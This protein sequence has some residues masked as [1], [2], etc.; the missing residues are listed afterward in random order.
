MRY[1]QEIYLDIVRVREAFK[2]INKYYK[3]ENKKLKE[4]EDAKEQLKFYYE[5]LSKI[6][7]K[8]DKV[9]FNKKIP[10]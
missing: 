4:L 5:N 10:K 3:K 6:K 2:K 9:L 7:R 8:E 1:L